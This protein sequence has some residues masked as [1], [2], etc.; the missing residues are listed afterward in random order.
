M[1]CENEIVHKVR[2]GPEDVSTSIDVSSSKVD[3]SES[4]PAS[5]NRQF[6][7]TVIEKVKLLPLPALL[8]KD[9]AIYLKSQ[10][11]AL[12]RNVCSDEDSRSAAINT[13]LATKRKREDDEH[14]TDEIIDNAVSFISSD[15]G[16]K[17][18]KR[19]RSSFPVI[20]GLLS[21]F[22]S[23]EKKEDHRTPLQDLSVIGFF[24][25]L[26]FSPSPVRSVDD[27]EGGVV[28]EVNEE[29]EESA[30]DT[31][32]RILAEDTEK[33]E[34]TAIG[35]KEFPM[36][37]EQVSPVKMGHTSIEE[38]E[39]KGNTSSL[40]LP[41]SSSSERKK[42]KRN[43]SDRIFRDR[44]EWFHYQVFQYLQHYKVM[45]HPIPL[46]HSI[47][48][49]IERNQRKRDTVTFIKPKTSKRK[50]NNNDK[51]Q[52]AYN[53]DQKEAATEEEEESA[54][55]G[56]RSRENKYLIG[57]GDNYGGDF[58]LY[59]GVDTPSEGHSVA[60]IRVLYSNKVR[61]KELSSS[62]SLMLYVFRCLL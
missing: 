45:N 61:N 28:M 27:N 34:E 19:R 55:E 7:K 16:V 5:Q 46:Y 13:P 51:D 1:G 36:D 50:E 10:E 41:R 47:A 32:H 35:W 3:S 6:Y 9:Q 37:D 38:E 49:L 52:A 40:S 60:T 57:P 62:V 23:D 56:D 58:T 31:Y 29:K 18:Q 11:Q 2:Q 26:F 30:N 42:I 25:N 48:P 12:N 8:W 20:D 54:V 59:Q 21:W 22:Q 14:S 4:H 44:E 15:D 39:E 33:P 43:K 53:H 24:S 17:S